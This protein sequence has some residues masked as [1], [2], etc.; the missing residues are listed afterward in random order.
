MMRILIAVAL[1][2]IVSVSCSMEKL[3][4]MKQRN[5]VHSYEQ[6]DFHDLMKRYVN[7]EQSSVGEIEGIYSVSMIVYKKG[8]GVLSS[9]EKEKVAERK[10][11]YTQVAIIKDTD[12]AN[13]EYVEVPLDKKFMPSYS[14]RG[15]FSRMAD[16]N[17]LIYKHFESRGRES[18]YTFTFDRAKDILEGVRKE[19]NGQFEYTYQLTYMKLQPKQAESSR[20]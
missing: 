1:I 10:E 5:K 12:G 15:E 4:S 17:I 8:K 11:N 3:Y 9:T 20:K 7:K 6:I 16:A 14:I 18:S 13:R 2:G 19:N